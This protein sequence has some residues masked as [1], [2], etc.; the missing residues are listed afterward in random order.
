LGVGAPGGGA[1]GAFGGGVDGTEAK[2]GSW[3]A[4]RVGAPTKD[5][6]WW[7]YK[8]AYVGLKGEARKEFLSANPPGDPAGALQGMVLA[9]PVGQHYF[10]RAAGTWGAVVP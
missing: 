4:S 5:A 1:A 6:C 10:L 9:S 3:G 8:R 2:A 7:A